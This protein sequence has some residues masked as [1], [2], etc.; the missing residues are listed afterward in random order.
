MANAENPAV[1]NSTSPG[2]ASPITFKVNLSSNLA[3]GRLTGRLFVIISRTNNPEPVSAI[4]NTGMSGPVIIARDVAANPSTQAMTLSGSDA[5][6]PLQRLGDLPFGEYY[7][8]TLLQTNQ[9]LLIPRGPGNLYSEARRV[10]IDVMQPEVIPSTLDRQFPDDDLSETGLVRFVRIKSERLSRFHG[11]PIHL[12][13]GVILP[14]DFE[15]GATNRPPLRVEIGG[16]ATR[17]TVVRELMRENSGFRRQW[18]DPSMPAMVLLHLDGAGPLGDPYQV[19]SANHGP[20]GDAI[21]NELIPHVEREFRCGG[22]SRSRVLS[23]GSTGGWVALALQVFYPDFFGGAW[24]GFPDPVDFRAYGLIDIYK[25]T[26]AYV[27]SLGFERPASRTRNGDVQFTVRHECQMENV[28]GA[29]NSYTMSGGQWG[30]WNATFGQRSTDGRPVPL[31]DPRTGTIH[32]GV[33]DSWRRYD[34]HRVLEQDWPALAPRLRG[35]LHIWVGESD[36]YFLNNAVHLLEEFL[37]RTDPPA[38]AH[39]QFGP[40]KRHGW[41]PQSELEL[42]QEM[43]AAIRNSGR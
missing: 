29:G 20:Y 15:A 37:R 28:L 13:A 17:C 10:R 26:N 35:K 7:I 43:S 16:F 23:G 25:D 22:D 2:H 6:F 1:A 19:N 27:N 31:W 34:L 42:M 24:A 33:A 8:Q 38:D 14:K 40:G 21:V 30:A 41:M 5:T 4:G 36:D 39:V 11:R 18:L 9:D 3:Q 12:R 32:Q